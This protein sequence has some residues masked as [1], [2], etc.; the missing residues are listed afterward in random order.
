M[1]LVFAGG[2]TGRRFSVSIPAKADGMRA[3]LYAQQAESYPFE[4]SLPHRLAG[5]KKLVDRM[6]R[7]DQSQIFFTAFGKR[8]SVRSTT[9]TPPQGSVIEGRAAVR[10]LV[11]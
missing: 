10:V 5:V 2:T 8:G 6:Q 3:R 11:S 1:R 4:R 7:N 9:L